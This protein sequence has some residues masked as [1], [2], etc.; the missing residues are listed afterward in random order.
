[1]SKQL[2]NTG[3]KESPYERPNQKWI[4][5]KACTSDPCDIGPSPDG[6][7]RMPDQKCKPIRSWRSRRGMATFL[8][9]M[10]TLVVLSLALIIDSKQSFKKASEFQL[11]IQTE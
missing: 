10:L 3:W 9:V 7:C 2:Q 8:I 4:C 6:I 5:G 11:T 1:M